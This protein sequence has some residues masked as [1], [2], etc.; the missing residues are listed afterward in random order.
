MMLKRMYFIGYFLLK[1]KPSIV[2]KHVLNQQPL[3]GPVLFCMFLFDYLDSN[4]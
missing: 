3:D 1:K 4:F 2:F